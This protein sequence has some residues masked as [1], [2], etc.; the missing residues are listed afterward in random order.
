MF[1][2]LIKELGLVRNFTRSGAVYRLEIDSGIIAKDAVTG[3][4]VA[5]N[6]VC[7]TLVE[8][9]SGLLKFDVMEETVRRTAL[10]AIRNGD[11]VNLEDSLK[12]G[13]N[14]SGHFV[15]GHVDCVGTVRNIEDTGGEHVIETGF[16]AEFSRLVVEKGSVALDGISLTVGKVGEG[17]FK[18]YIIPHTLKMTN[19]GL[20]RRLDKVNIEFDI[21]G[22]YLARFRDLDNSGGVTEKFLKNMGF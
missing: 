8:K 4:S 17:A 19:L 12:A 11:K 16:P 3:D 13:G 14:L 7:L 1:T 9:N 15:L 21:I 10:L 22:K 20:R 18:V 6:G 2:G 5:V